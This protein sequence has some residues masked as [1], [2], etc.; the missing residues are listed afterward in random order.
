[1][2]TRLAIDEDGWFHTG[3]IGSLDDGKF[4]MVTDRKKEVFKL[5][6]GKF[7]APQILE[8]HLKESVF[9]EQ[10]CVVGEAEKFAGALISPNLP[11]MEKQLKMQ[12]L[13]FSSA[14][15]L[16]NSPAAMELIKKEIQQINR[17]L[18][19]HERIGQFRLVP[20]EWTPESG[21]LSPTLKLR[22]R[23][24]HEKYRDLIDQLYK[25]A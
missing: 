10:S 21:E 11:A 23:V 18:S 5:S 8:G 17:K 12:N 1:V 19:Q 24:I 15:E 22:R 14:E 7:V 3:D 2:Q 25:K 4:L 16:V 6:N 13:N 9:I 20:H